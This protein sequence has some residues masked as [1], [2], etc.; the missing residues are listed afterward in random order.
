MVM[1]EGV[2]QD[3]WIWE[4][5]FPGPRRS[6]SAQTFT[7]EVAEFPFVKR[8]VSLVFPTDGALIL[9]V[10]EGKEGKVT[11]EETAGVFRV[12][13][14]VYPKLDLARAYIRYPVTEDEFSERGSILPRDVGVIT[15]F[16]RPNLPNQSDQ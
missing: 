10:T 3:P 13:V 5:T 16:Q 8:V 9:V 15:L 11:P 14:K 7:E 6:S 2:E 1:I 4:D 12:M